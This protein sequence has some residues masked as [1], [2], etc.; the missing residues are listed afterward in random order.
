MPYDHKAKTKNIRQLNDYMLAKTLSMFEYEGLPET[1]PAKE[2]EKLL[3]KSGY[4]FITKAPDGQIYAFNGGLG[5]DQDV[6]GNPT[7]IVISN[8]A[9]NFNKTCDLKKDGVLIYSDDMKMGLLTYFEKQNTL[10]A[11]N[12]INMVMWGYNSRNQKMI[13]AP[14][15]KTRASAE[16]YLK[17]IIDGELS[18]VA[19]NAFFEG[20]NLQSS[21][22]GAAV[23]VQQMIEY[24]QYIKGSMFNEVGLSAAFNMKRERLISSEL[25][26]SE[27][28]IFALVYNMM[29]NRIT[30]VEEINAMFGTDIKV[31]F[32]SVWKYKEKSL[33]DDVVGDE[34]DLVNGDAESGA[35]GESGDGEESEQTN[36]NTD[37]DTDTDTG[38]EATGNDT[39]TDTDSDSEQDSV[40]NDE[41]SND[42]SN[43]ESETNESDTSEENDQSQESE[44]GADNDDEKEDDK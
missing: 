8:P 44:N 33:V 14:D 26:Q 17:K 9:I 21:P 1:I 39:D 12:D 37:T 18:V 25:D 30:G 41:S 34:P 2:L 28:S 6:Y 5:G 10:L 15:D 19:E 29:D 20:V 40:N 11:E 3:Q 43:D 23:T 27:D 31:D 7:Q 35:D 16:L 36:T 4:A 13:S 24:H 38:A 42:D 32:G 22:S